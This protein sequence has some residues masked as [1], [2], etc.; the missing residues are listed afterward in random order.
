M[1]K[2]KLTSNKKIKDAQV[3]SYFKVKKVVIGLHRGESVV[4]L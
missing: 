3:C 1:P 4:S 2:V